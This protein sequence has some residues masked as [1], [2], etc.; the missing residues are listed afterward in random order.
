MP[1]FDQYRRSSTAPYNSVS[2]V[3]KLLEPNH[4]LNQIIESFLNINFNLM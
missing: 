4:E 2:Q 1:Q 3:T